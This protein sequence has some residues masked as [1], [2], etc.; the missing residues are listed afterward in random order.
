[1]AHY[2]MQVA[3]VPQ[4]C[5]S[6]D[7]RKGFLSLLPSEIQQQIINRSHSNRLRCEQCKFL[8]MSKCTT[9]LKHTGGYVFNDN[10]NDVCTF[11]D[12]LK[13]KGLITTYN[14]DD[15]NDLKQEHILIWADQTA[16]PDANSLLIII[17]FE[18]GNGSRF[19]KKEG[20]HVV[21]EIQILPE[22]I[23]KNFSEEDIIF[24]FLEKIKFIF[25]KNAEH[26]KRKTREQKKL[27]RQE[28]VASEI[29]FLREETEREC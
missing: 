3:N 22:Y 1:M 29:Y 16:I 17:N 2:G 15:W 14:S 12:D 23:K 19:L 7:G 13:Q 6:C 9:Y 21:F 8:E 26:K 27:Q 5:S 11:V 18:D 25:N 24:D 10:E 4:F 28:D 20:K